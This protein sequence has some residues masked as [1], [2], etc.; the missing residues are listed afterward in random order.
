[1]LIEWSL[2]V[3][4][5][6][7]IYFAGSR[8]T[9]YADVLGEKWG[10]Q[11]SFIGL[12]LLSTVT[13]LP[14]LGTSLSSIVWVNSPDLALG[15]VLGSNLFNL[16]IIP[17]L[18]LLY[19]KAFLHRA[20]LDHNTN[21]ALITII[22]ALVGGGLISHLK[23][24]P[25][26]LSV[27]FFVSPFSIVLF[28]FYLGGIYLIF[29]KKDV[30]EE[31]KLTRA[32]IYGQN[33]QLLTT[34]LFSGSALLVIGAG[35]GLARVGDI[36]AVKTGLKATFFG[37]FFFAFVTSLPEIVVSWT[38]LKQLDAINLA[39][40]N[41]FGSCL[42]NLAIIFIFD[43]AVFGPVFAAV[44]GTHLVSVFAGIMMVSIASYAIH[45]RRD[46]PAGVFFPPE[47]VLLAGV[48]L[49]AL[50]LIFLLR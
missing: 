9:Y 12:I 21:A 23:I 26:W 47:M 5:S 42:F 28:G 50:Y 10:V 33:S 44:T 41:I 2:F 19:R 15:N 34:L 20:R 29:N 24:F 7:V 36:L 32:K 37:T 31:Q 35:A 22:Y 18:A 13:S 17:L 39:L 48:Y 8:L 30:S 11:R 6:V 43:L 46:D 16:A 38:A 25:A 1:M 4:L 27:E 14:E 45:I 3:I 40:G 49:G